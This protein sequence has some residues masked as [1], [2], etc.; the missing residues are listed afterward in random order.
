MID[1]AK[2]AIR[3]AIYPTQAE[4]EAADL[5]TLHARIKELENT[6]HEYEIFRVIESGTA[7]R[8]SLPEGITIRLDQYPGAADCL[9]TGG[10]GGRPVDEPVFTADG[11]HITGTL[12]ADGSYSLSGTPAAYPVWIVFQIECK[13][14][15]VHKVSLSERA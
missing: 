11:V 13:G 4:R 12:D 9:I 5:S 15:D 6:D 1:H 3:Q 10:A 2:E 7:G 8:I 14:K